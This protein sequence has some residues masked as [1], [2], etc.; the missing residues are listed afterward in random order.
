MKIYNTRARVSV[1]V[2]IRTT[3]Y[4]HYFFIKESRK[5]TSRKRKKKIWREN[6]EEGREQKNRDDLMELSKIN[7]R[8]IL[9]CHHPLFSLFKFFSAYIFGSA[10]FL[11]FTKNASKNSNKIASMFQ[12]LHVMYRCIIK[13]KNDLH[14]PRFLFYAV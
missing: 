8:K 6:D 13:W 3:L 11:I 1:H 2:Y 5:T 10:S 7:P 4:W 9:K 14:Y 12:L